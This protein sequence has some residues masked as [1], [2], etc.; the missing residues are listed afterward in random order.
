VCLVNTPHCTTLHT[1]FEQTGIN[2]PGKTYQFLY[3]LLLCFFVLF[4]F[5]LL[6]FVL[7]GEIKVLEVNNF[8]Q[9]KSFTKS[10]RNLS[11]SRLVFI[12]F[13]FTILSL[14]KSFHY[15]S[16]WS[17]KHV[18][19]YIRGSWGFN[20]TENLKCEAGSKLPLSPLKWMREKPRL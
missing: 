18:T 10:V 8:V 11:L 6:C 5:V 20:S 15:Q 13:S 16:Y 12:T 7:F 3:F 2:L 17:T 1:C 4:C 14:P 9:C 19:E